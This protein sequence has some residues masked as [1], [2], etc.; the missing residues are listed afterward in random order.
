MPSPYSLPDEIRN[1]RKPKDVEAQI[2]LAA[3]RCLYAWSVAAQDVPTGL[4]SFLV[5]RKVL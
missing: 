2:D 5:V 3:R 4:T 1:G